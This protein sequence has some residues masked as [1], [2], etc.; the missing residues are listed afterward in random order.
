MH[1][2]SQTGPASARPVLRYFRWAFIVTAIGLALGAA[3]GWQRTG[4]FG[5]MAGILFICT[6]LAVLEISLSFDNAIV[7]ANKLKTMQPKWQHRFL[8]WGIVIAVFG[9][10]IVFPLLIVVI[11][12]GIGPWQAVVLAASRPE[13]YAR[14]MHEARLPIAAFGG[15]LFATAVMIA[16][17]VSLV[18]LVVQLVTGILS[19]SAPALNLFALGLP[20]GVLAGLA[21]L[22]AAY[23]IITDQMADLSATAV[24]ESRSILVR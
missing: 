15:T 4:T 10:R 17:P 12:A 11:A 19:R 1:D 14:I 24:A 5:G 9:M 6:V 13:E 20:A 23:P 2:G 8:T 7:N 21:A 22:I 18:L 3:L 16:L